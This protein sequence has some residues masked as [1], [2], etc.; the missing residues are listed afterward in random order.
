L[1]QALLPFPVA[2][3]TEVLRQLVTHKTETERL[4]DDPAEF[5]GKLIIDCD[6]VSRPMGEVIEPWQAKDFAELDKGWRRAV[7]GK[8]DGKLLAYLERSKGH[9]KTTDMAAMAS[10]ALYAS[11]RKLRGVVGAADKGQAGLLRDAVDAM[12][13][14]NP[15]LAERLE[16]QRWIVV[17]KETGSNLEILSADEASSHGELPDFVIVDELTHHKK[18]GL[19]E[20]LFAGSAKRSNCMLVVMSNAGLGKGSS[21]QWKVREAFRENTQCYFSRLDGPVASWLTAD[22][23]AVQR[24]LLPGRAYNRLWLNQWQM[25]SGDALDPSAVEACCVLDGPSGPENGWQFVG[26]LDL[27]LK[28][29]HAAWVVLGCSETERKVKVAKVMSWKPS[30]PRHEIDLGAVELAILKDAGAYNL[31]GAYFDPWQAHYMAQRLRN[32]GLRMDEVVLSSPKT[33]KEIATCLIQAFAHGQLELYRHPELLS[34]LAKL[35][36]V[37][38]TWGVK[39]TAVSDENGHADRAVSLAMGLPGALATCD[40]LMAGIHLEVMA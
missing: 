28:K 18:P 25:E 11:P 24:A 6:G 23:L 19:W 3:R 12:Y 8:G 26:T 33:Q 36:I 5:R 40:G 22:K 17:N 39:L 37:E 15:W 27:G 32:V 1:I 13:R 38:T 21:W 4:I 35:S 9:S 7:H 20:S 30:G 2:T 34:D 29:D 16:V 14:L 31:L 10:W